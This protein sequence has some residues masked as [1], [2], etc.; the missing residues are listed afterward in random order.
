MSDGSALQHDGL[1]DGGS[2]SKSRTLKS[3]TVAAAG[4]I[5]AT[6]LLAGC[7]EPK[8]APMND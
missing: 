2:P 7:G 5:A 3:V 1:A 6:T 8:A 4:L